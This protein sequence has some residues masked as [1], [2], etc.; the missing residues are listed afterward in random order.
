MNIIDKQPWQTTIPVDGDLFAAAQ[1]KTDIKELKN[2][3]QDF[4]WYP[5]T[6]EML[7]RVREQIELMGAGDRLLDI[8]AGNGSALMAMAS[9]CSELFAIEISPILIKQMDKSIVVIG[10]DF[11]AQTLIDKKVDVIFSNPPYSKFEPWMI[12]IIKE[13]NAKQVL[14]IVP[15]RWETSPQIAK[16]LHDRNVSAKIIDSFDFMDAERPSR[17]KV[18]LVEIRYAEKE[19]YSSWS[20][21][22]LDAFNLWFDETFA[23]E[24]KVAHESAQAYKFNLKDEI[25]NAVIYGKDLIN[26]LFELY[27]VEIKNLI[28]TYRAIAT[29][30]G[31]LLSELGISKKNTLES[32]AQKIA[33]LKARYWNE[34]FG[35]M[36]QITDRLTANSRKLLLDKITCHMDVDFSPENAYAIAIWAI[37]NANMFLDDQ[38]I[39]LFF[40]LTT[41]EGIKHFKSNEHWSDDSFRYQHWRARNGCTKY[42]LD[43]RFVISR[44]RLMYVNDIGCFRSNYDRYSGIHDE[45]GDLLGDIFTTAKNLGFNVHNTL[46]MTSW[47]RG[48]ENTFTMEHNGIKVDFMKVRPYLNGNMHIKLNQDFMLALNVEVARILH[49]GRDA[50]HAAEEM[51]ESLARVEKVFNSHTRLEL[52]PAK[53]IGPPVSNLTKEH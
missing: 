9:V 39:K 38:L 27:S 24:I 20:H 25:E 46:L 8:G 7:S 1:A 19:C 17:A 41:N 10:T 16:A 31:E 34:L 44:Y 13:C 15:Q 18:H 33:G 53:L 47:E 48:V 22:A 45:A 28:R 52:N 30:N 51:G 36:E 32:M 3:Q 12:K 11:T 26:R 4:E 29:I 37:K 2:N 35:N 40:D 42:S 43:Y 23:E 50:K 5:T 14:L 21:D 6:P 49:G